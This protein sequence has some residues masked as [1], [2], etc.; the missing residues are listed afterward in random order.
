MKTSLKACRIFSILLCIILFF[1][2]FVSN[3]FNKVKS[4]FAFFLI[5]YWLNFRLFVKPKEQK[6]INK[7]YVLIWIF[8]LAIIFLLTWYI[9]GFFYNIKISDGFYTNPIK[10]I[11]KPIWTNIFPHIIIIIY[12]E[13]IRTLVIVQNNKKSTIWITLALIL[14]DIIL[15]INIYH[16]SNLEG[17]LEII[18]CLIIPSISLNLL[19]NYLCRRYGSGANIVFKL[20]T[21]IIYNYYMPILPDIYPIYETLIKLIYPLII[22]LIIDYMFTEHNQ[23][24]LS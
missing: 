24:I 4:V 2:L 21:I 3:Y 14:L 11:F 22:Y 18:G 6:N 20:V 15:S 1:N 7:K 19:C 9:M 16:Y 17:I 5:V 8:I 10:Y 13:L 12:S 23:K